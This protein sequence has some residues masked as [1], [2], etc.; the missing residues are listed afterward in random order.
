M[1]VSFLG[2]LKKYNSGIYVSW[3]DNCVSKWLSYLPIFTGEAYW[4]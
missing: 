3:A 4:C 2:F 1:P